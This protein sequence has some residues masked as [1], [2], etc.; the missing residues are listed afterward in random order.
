M[1]LLRKIRT[2]VA[3]T[4]RSL[5]YDFGR[6][7]VEPPAGGPDVTSTGMSTFAVPA[8]TAYTDSQV[9]ARRPRRALTA[10]VFG[11]LTVAGAAAAYLGVVNGLGSLTQER[12]AAAETLPAR[13]AAT[14]KAQVGEGPSPSRVLPPTTAGSTIAPAAVGA[15]VVV[16]GPGQA[17]QPG[18]TRQPKPPAVANKPA[19]PTN[20]DCDC[21]NPP[22]P[23]PTAPQAPTP[24]PSSASP[25]AEEPSPSESSAAPDASGEPS[26][27]PRGRHRRHHR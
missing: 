25:S 3:G 18:V 5:R 4:W 9:V 10:G 11:V 1:S 14:S 2:E 13:P 27:S 16:V 12:P 7:P 21:G 23:T 6:R 22:V 24:T 8:V 26:E 19:D 15:G 17:P 20:H